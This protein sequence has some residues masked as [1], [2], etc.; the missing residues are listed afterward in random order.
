MTT[1]GSKWPLIALCATCTIAAAAAA[2]AAAAVAGLPDA[3]IARTGV[4]ERHYAISYT[5][6]PNWKPGLPFRD[7]GLRDHFLYLKRL[8]GEGRIVIG[9]PV[10]PDSG[11]VVLVAVDQATADRVAAA[12]PA[13]TAGVFV[14]Q[15][16]PF[17]PRFAAK[18]PVA[19]AKP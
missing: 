5:P 10:E 7:Q 11:L 19:V 16:R 1:T 15:V 18:V 17:T 2:G 3:D 12:D 4:S 9:G 13:V 8:D 14:V 6:G